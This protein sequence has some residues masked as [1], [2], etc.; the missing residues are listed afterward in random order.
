M[1]NTAPVN[2]ESTKELANSEAVAYYDNNQDTVFIKENIGDSTLLFQNVALEL[3]YAELSSRSDTY[4]RKDLSFHAVCV[5]YMLCKKYGV[6][7]KGF[8]IERMP[9][10][11]KDM[12]PKDIRAEL[13]KIRT[14]MVDVHSR[15][16]DEL[17]R[18][19]QARS[20]EYER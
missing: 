5:G 20:K 13:S 14:A 1:I 10:E 4:S 9:N 11:W 3:G 8:A 15:I 19:Q 2:C 16:S 18:Q 17:Y 6:D 7:T 12:E